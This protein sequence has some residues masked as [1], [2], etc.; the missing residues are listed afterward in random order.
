ML[1]KNTN[2]FFA[3]NSSEEVVTPVKPKSEPKDPL[4]KAASEP[5][6][7][8]GQLHIEFLDELT[9]ALEE[10]TNGGVRKFKC[11]GTGCHLYQLA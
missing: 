8:T 2:E 4:P 5:P 6:Q 10:W 7:L 9:I 1:G 3:T 11:T